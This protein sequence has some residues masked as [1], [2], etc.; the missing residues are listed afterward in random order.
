MEPLRVGVVGLGDMGMTHV[1]CFAASADVTLAAVASKERDRLDALAERFAGLGTYDDWTGLVARDDLDAIAVVTPNNLHAPITTAALASGKHVL[2]EKPMALSSADARAMSQAART[3]DRA[4]VT[5]FNMRCRGDFQVLRDRVESGELGE[6]HYAR[7]RW[8]RRRGIPS[9][10][11]WFTD[12]ALAGGGPLIDLGVH[13]LDLA[14]VLLGEPAVRSVTAATYAEVAPALQPGFAVE[15]LATAF[16]GFT[17]GKTL[18]LETSWAA[19]GAQHDD[20]GVTVYGSTGGAELDIRDYATANTLRVFRDVD[21]VPAEERPS[22]GL[23]MGH[24]TVVQDFLG[25][26]RSGSW[27][28]H[29]GSEGVTRAA[30]IEA[31]YAS[32]AS[33][34]EVVLSD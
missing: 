18:Q 1:E 34:S 28:A 29:D 17:D 14:L 5:V 7:A 27:A 31:C 32:A 13:V 9:S 26:V 25:V 15:D 8:L 6:L 21:G 33:G 10:G 20:F 3:A 24:W 19:H 11:T 22:V 16:I 4:L 12:P 23:G 30:I 2:C